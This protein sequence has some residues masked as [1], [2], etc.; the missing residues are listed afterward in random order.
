MRKN[1]AATV[2]VLEVAR[3]GVV[4]ETFPDS[5]AILKRLERGDLGGKSLL[6]VGKEATA[7]DWVDR[8]VPTATTRAGDPCLLLVQ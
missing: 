1:W 3:D 2:P 6:P 8:S 7:W 5:L 4:L